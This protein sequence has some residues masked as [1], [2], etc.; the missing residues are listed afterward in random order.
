MIDSILR[1]E[2]LGVE[3]TFEYVARL[4]FE[5][6]VLD[7]EHKRQVETE[8]QLAKADYYPG[9]K[10]DIERAPYVIETVIEKAAAIFQTEYGRIEEEDGN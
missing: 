1:W 8:M 9:L 5:F 3:D 2:L 4:C 10:E 6:G 7:L